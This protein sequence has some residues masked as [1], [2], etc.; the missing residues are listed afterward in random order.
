MRSLAIVFIYL[1]LPASALAQSATVSGTIADTSGA[2]VPGATV[3]L[4]GPGGQTTVSDAQGGYSFRNVAQGTYQITATL[5]GFA[6]V[7][8]N[9]VN[10]ASANVEVPRL[11]LAI[12]ALGE[13]VV[14]S[15][16][17]IDTALV[18]APATMSVVTSDTL[19]TTPAQN[20]ADLLRG[21][22]GVN[23]IQTSARDVNLTSRQATSTLSNSQLVL[24]DGRSVYL[25][26]FGLVLWDFVPANL[27]DVKQI[28][29]IRGPASA[30]WGA[31]AL[32]GVVN[33][34][35]KSPREQKGTNVVLSAG[36][37][38]RDAGSGVGK[39]AGAVFGANAT[40][41]DAPNS[42]WSYRV[43][44]GYFNSDAFPRPTGRI[45]VIADPRIP[46]ATVGGALYPADGPGAPGTA[47]QNRGT[48]QPKF[49]MR[50]DQE[51]SGGRITYAGGVAGSQGIIHTGI[52]PFDIQKG[53]YIGYGKV[54]YTKGALKVNAF[55]NLVSAEA[56]NLLLVNPATGQPLQLNF[57]TQT[58]DVEAGDAVR[59]GSRQVVSFGGNVRRNNFDITIAP[60]AENR[61]EIGGYAQDEIFLDPV[62]LTIGGRVD[63]FGNLSDPVFSPRIA[64]VVTVAPSQTVRASFNRAFRSPS[65]INNYLSTQIVAPTDLSGLAPLL[66][67]PLQ[68]LVAQPF[69]LVVNAVGSKIPIN[70]APQQELTEESLTAYEVAYTAS[71]M[72]TTATAAFYVN[73]L[74][75]N[76]N[77][78]QL[79]P[80]LD[81]YTAANPPPGWPLPP[82]IL[83][84]LAQ[85]GIFL[86]RTAFTYLNLGP[87]R[88]KGIELSVD[89]RF[90]AGVSAFANYS[91]QA[92][93][94][95]IDSATPF[96]AEE[97]ALPPTNRFN[98]G[99]SFDVRRLLGSGSVQYTDKAFWSDVLT[100]PYHGFTDAY[101][102]V[103][104]TFGVKWMQG[105][106]TTLVKATNLL[107][108]D[109]QQHVFGD[110]L[111]RTIIGEVR[112]AY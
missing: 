75:H 88:E 69:P 104:G 91:W 93:P 12:G 6:P 33:I 45:P 71:I 61:T 11:T 41:A 9:D 81:P 58:F 99:A 79:P 98:I 85:R 90:A 28:E 30:V 46:G 13:T 1:F 73:D 67:P 80:N 105:R 66:P 4:T 60:S 10:V 47:F 48:S 94:S 65:V 23:A 37:F 42:I 112:I 82:A 108:S 59:F 103:N 102:M 87:V 22:P 56:P 15:A 24:V 62:R 31:N 52:G 57:S 36:G 20:Y 74:D 63:K 53:S 32:T 49:D 92:K 35:T 19:A 77:F 17:R 43:S 106:V 107:N 110:I 14:V 70:G 111:K 84:L 55:A 18:D 68:P 8:R 72:R 96:P 44:A 51:I 3:V 50:V 97:L 76:I 27:G 101:T 25:D 16:S 86:P 34:I 100:S 26:F 2:V 5:P 89:H 83:A 95:V 40:F 64:A 54:N 38:S 21:V 39:G 29:V 109:I 7:T 78:V